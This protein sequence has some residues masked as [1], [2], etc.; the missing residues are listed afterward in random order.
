[1]PMSRGAC[2]VRFVPTLYVHLDHVPADMI[3]QG[4]AFVLQ[5]HGNSVVKWPLGLLT[6]FRVAPSVSS[7]AMESLDPPDR[8]DSA[9][10]LEDDSEA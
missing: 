4:V 9:G 7:S 8:L 2:H 1:M 5:E 6:I 10:Y 3:L